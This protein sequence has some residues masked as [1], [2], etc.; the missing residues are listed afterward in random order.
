MM[1]AGEDIA[2]GGTSAA[3][4]VWASLLAMAAND[5]GARLGNINALLYSQP[6]AGAARSVDDG[7]N[8]RHYKAA[9]GWDAC[10]GLGSPKWAELCSALKAADTAEGAETAE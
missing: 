5:V 1:I 4:P 3:A 2:N 7:S 10:T 6:F 9:V 8:G